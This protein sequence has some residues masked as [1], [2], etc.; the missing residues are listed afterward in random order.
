MK[1][2]PQ[3]SVSLDPALTKVTITDREHGLL[4]WQV[5]AVAEGSSA[6]LLLGL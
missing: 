2:S 1:T 5:T 4:S 3:P 6:S